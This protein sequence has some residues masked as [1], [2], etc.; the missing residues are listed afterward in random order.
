MVYW[1]M[2]CERTR[3]KYAKSI[4]VFNLIALVLRETRFRG[5]LHDNGATFTPGR[6]EKLHR[7]YIK[8]CLLGCESYSAVKLMKLNLIRTNSH[9][10]F[11]WHRNEF[12]RGTKSSLRHKNRG[13]LA[14][15]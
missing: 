11:T 2:N 1:G 13:E 5:F 14:P 12:S 6:D 7:V 3:E 8:P 4:G 10:P 9:T 15:V